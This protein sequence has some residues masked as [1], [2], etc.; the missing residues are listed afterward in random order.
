MPCLDDK[1][2]IEKLYE[3]EIEIT[4][5]I[6]V[7]DTQSS[8]ECRGVCFPVYW[9][10]ISCGHHCDLSNQKPKTKTHKNKVTLEHTSAMKAKRGWN[11]RKS[12]D[13]GCGGIGVFISRPTCLTQMPWLDRAFFVF[14]LSWI[15]N[16]ILYFCLKCN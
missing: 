1:K 13:T 2:N 4:Q 6:R 15:T 14:Y 10:W 12:S 16:Y 11:Q 9:A 5:V 8:L 7:V 3:R